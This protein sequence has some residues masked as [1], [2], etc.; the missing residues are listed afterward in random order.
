MPLLTTQ[1]WSRVAAMVGTGVLFSFV[2]ASGQANPAFWKLEWPETDFSKHS[3]P[4]DEV[5]SGVC[6][7]RWYPTDLQSEVFFHRR[8]LAPL[9]GY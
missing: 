1:K 9:S 2:T 8:S 5:F 7:P 4:F 6:A 3:I